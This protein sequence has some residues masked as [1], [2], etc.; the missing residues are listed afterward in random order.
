MNGKPVMRTKAKVSETQTVQFACLQIQVSCLNA[1][2]ASTVPAFS[3]GSTKER[4]ALFVTQQ[5]WNRLRPIAKNAF[6]RR[7][8]ALDFEDFL[9]ASHSFAS[10]AW[11]DHLD[12]EVLF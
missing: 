11:L 9:N 6:A 1:V 8:T 7:K 4:R 12:F 5:K 3:H 10:S 2:I